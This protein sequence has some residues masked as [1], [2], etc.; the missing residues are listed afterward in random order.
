MVTM[1]LSADNTCDFY[2]ALHDQQNFNAESFVYCFKIQG[3]WWV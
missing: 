3:G 2:I 1:V